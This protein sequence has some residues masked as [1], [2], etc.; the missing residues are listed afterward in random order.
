[1]RPLEILIAKRQL[2]TQLSLSWAPMLITGCVYQI[3]G[4]RSGSR[5]LDMKRPSSECHL[6]VD[7]DGWQGLILG[8]RKPVV[9][10][11]TV[12]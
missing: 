3:G 7:Q 1:M 11:T 9:P 4:K 6:L 5:E 2:S 12:T 10:Q 8:G